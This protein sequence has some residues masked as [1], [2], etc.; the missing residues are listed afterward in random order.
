MKE[1]RMDY[2]KIDKGGMSNV[3]P[4]FDKSNQEIYRRAKAKADQEKK[5]AEIDALCRHVA[6]SDEH[7]EEG[8]KY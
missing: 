4:V 1:E 8:T 6:D 5:E 3:P 7:C 2:H